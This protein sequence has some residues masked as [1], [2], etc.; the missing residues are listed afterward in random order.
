MEK[1]GSNNA[2]YAIVAD[3]LSKKYGKKDDI[4]NAVERISF[5]V[6]HGELFGIIGPDG[7]GKTSLFRMLTTLLIPD[8]GSAS[9]DGFDVVKDYKQIRQRVGY[10]PGKFSL[11][12]DLTV[13]ENLEF[14]ATIFNT[15]IEANYDLVKN[16]YRQIEP[17]NDRK[18][19]KLSGGMKQKLALS[20]ALI[21]RPSVLFLD[22][23]TTGVDAVSRKEFWAM[24]KELKAQGITILVST[25][26]MDE[27]ELCDRVALMH[28]GRILSIDSP[29]NIIAHFQYPLFAARS[30][31][32]LALLRSLKSSEYVR[33]AYPFGEFHH[34]VMNV[35]G[36]EKELQ[37]QLMKEDQLVEFIMA[38]PNIEDCFINMTSN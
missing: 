30:G 37:S 2:V 13:K 24:L 4:I 38:T 9:V 25:P 20:C 28:H 34:I 18:A 8:E 35:I 15:S 19:G 6:D 16:I 36:K 23:P 26:Y 32:M 14:F 21:H 31:N 10:M 11:Y 1:S 27:A 22:E 7:A 29:K 12:Q 17:F 3:S 5:N 33:D